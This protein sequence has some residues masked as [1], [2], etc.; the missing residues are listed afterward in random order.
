MTK[1]EC[2]RTCRSFYLYFLKTL[3]FAQKRKLRHNT[4][5]LNLSNEFQ[6]ILNTVSDQESEQVDSKM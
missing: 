3:L 6:I 4:E 5:Y 2:S 1:N